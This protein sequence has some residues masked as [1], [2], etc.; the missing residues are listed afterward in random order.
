VKKAEATAP[1]QATACR[2]P[3]RP[4]A[5]HQRGDA[6][7]S[8]QP[9]SYQDHFAAAGPHLGPGASL[10]APAAAALVIAWAVSPAITFVLL[11]SK[12]YGLITG[13]LGVAAGALGLLLAIAAPSR[14]AE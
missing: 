8:R 1:P 2:D 4:S 7:A 14:L 5:R 11:R 3:R 10:I 12:G 9:L 13:G 6:V